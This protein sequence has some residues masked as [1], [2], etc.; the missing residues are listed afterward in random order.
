[1]KSEIQTFLKT[2][3]ISVHE[4]SPSMKVVFLFVYGKLKNYITKVYFS[5]KLDLA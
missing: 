5:V 4:E 1:M 3:S 2:T